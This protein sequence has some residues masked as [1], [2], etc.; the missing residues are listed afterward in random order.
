MDSSSER[1]MSMTQF[2]S[3]SSNERYETVS[4]A[5]DGYTSLDQLVSPVGPQFTLPLTSVDS[6]KQSAG[7]AEPIHWFGENQFHDNLGPVYAVPTYPAQH[8]GGV[9]TGHPQ[10]NLTYPALYDQNQFHHNLGPVY[11]VPTYPWAHGNNYQ[12]GSCNCQSQHGNPQHTGW[13]QSQQMGIHP[14]AMVV[15][16][17]C[18]SWYPIGHH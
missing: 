15:P 12:T 8:G 17:Y 6:Q 14:H 1:R 4:H 13:G 11:P 3:T 10:E 7:D 2:E 16:F 9:G 5:S 18:S